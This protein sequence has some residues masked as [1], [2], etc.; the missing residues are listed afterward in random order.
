MISHLGP[1]GIFA[2]GSEVRQSFTGLDAEV[3]PGHAITKVEA[4]LYAYT[5]AKLSHDFKLKL[6]VGDSSKD[7]SIKHEW[8]D[9][10]IGAANAGP[11][12]VDITGARNWQWI[13]FYSEFELMLEQYPLDKKE[14][15]YY[16]AIGLR[17]TSAPG[18]DTSLDALTDT[19]EPDTY[20]D[21]FQQFN[22]YNHVIGASELWNTYSKL[23]GKDVRVAVVDSGIA[24][25][26]D[27]KVKSKVNFNDSYHDSADRYGHGTFVAGI[28]AGNG[29]SSKGQYIGVAPKATLY[30]VRVS[31]D[32]GMT[33]ISDVI[34]SLQWIYENKDKHKIRVVNM[35]LNQSVPESYH[36][37]PLNAAVEILWFN[38]IVVV[39]SAG[40]NG[41]TTLYPPA[42]DPFVI[43]VGATD[44]RGTVTLSDDM[45]ATFSAYG[46]TEDGYSKPDLVAPGR[47]V[48]G[49]LPE[50]GK[51]NMGKA[52]PKNRVDSTYFKMSGTSV[53][54][55]MVSGAIALLLQDEPDLNPDQVK[56]RLM[57]T[58]NKDWAG[59]NPTTAG[60]GYL[61]I[62][63]AVYANTT[64]SANQGL[65]PS[66]LLYTGDD[67]IAWGSVGWNSVGWN[68]V[69][70]NSVGWNSVG[71]NSVGWNSVGWNSDHWDD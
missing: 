22:V 13:D 63:A 57:A 33:Y 25:V 48:I 43:T 6:L 10:N 32:D 9:G 37:S 16:D 7:I 65:L 51:L 12:V 23:Q 34:D 31:A 14:M 54:T 38:G 46:T 28:I 64:E 19:V 59:Y 11:V 68:S 39:V 29:K 5:P 53:S 20:I 41:T 55:P 8:F 44:D 61:D 21:P 52:H 67:P 60:A 56:Y 47:N 40:N 4:V 15:V 26:K 50:N 2:N 36:T 30:N 66:Q 49:L 70:W 62:Y 24:K 17:V 27:L 71:W 18:T 58:A 3:T 1:D 35:S 42:N 45:V 69:G